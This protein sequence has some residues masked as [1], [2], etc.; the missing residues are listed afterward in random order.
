MGG[1]ITFTTESFQGSIGTDANGNLEI[2]T[3]GTDKQIIFDNR[4]VISGSKEYWKDDKGNLDTKYAFGKEDVERLREGKPLKDKDG[5]KIP[6]KFSRGSNT[7]G[8]VIMSG[9]LS[10]TGPA[11]F[12]GSVSSEI[13]KISA[14]DTTPS[15]LGGTIFKTTNTGKSST[16][17]K[18]FDDGKSGQQ[19]IILIEDTLTDFAHDGGKIP[20]TNGLKLNGATDWTTSN[21]NDSITFIYNGSKWIEI[22][23]SDNS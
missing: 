3:D 18:A 16:L 10:T 22:N 15:V 8:S 2:K 11:I 5:A 13:V 19:I 20:T 9:S 7:T 14:G 1:F 4:K 21:T 17:I 12:S 6:P 23:R